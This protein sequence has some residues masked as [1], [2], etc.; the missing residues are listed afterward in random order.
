MSWPDYINKAAEHLWQ[1]KLIFNLEKAMG[2]W[3]LLEWHNLIIYFCLQPLKPPPSPRSIKPVSGRSPSPVG[4]PSPQTWW[5]SMVILTGWWSALLCCSGWWG[6]RGAHGPQGPGEDSCH[7]S[8]L[9]CSGLAAPK[10]EERDLTHR[11]V[12]Q[13]V[14]NKQNVIMAV[15]KIK[16]D[17]KKI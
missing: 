6:W 14:R 2:L 8:Q 12:I 13:V 17:L 4:W 10:R 9:A 16:T 7:T 3:G 15:T 11:D 1:G 5:S